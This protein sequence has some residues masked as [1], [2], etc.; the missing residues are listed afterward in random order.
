MSSAP[1][2]VV[3]G[4]TKRFR[5]PHEQ[6]HTLK[7]RALHPFRRTGYDQFVAVDDVAFHVEQGEFFGIAGRNGSGKSTLLK[8]IAGIYRTNAGEIWVNGRMSTFIEL[9][10][11]F[12]PDLAARDN[13]ILNGIML[14]LTPGEARERY[15]RVLEFSELQEFET[16]KLKNYS[17]GMHVRL[18]FAVMIQVDA[19]VLLIDEVLAVGD[20]AFQQKCFD[21]FNKLRDAG[22]TI[23]LVTHDMGAIKRFCHRAM[24]MERGRVVVMGDP[25][26]VGDQYFELNFRRPDP[27]EPAAAPVLHDPLDR[28]GDGR[29][30]WA[31]IWLQTPDGEPLT[32][33]PQGHE[34]VIRGTVEFTE[35]LTDPAIGLTIENADRVPVFSTS[36]MWTEERTG[37][38]RAGD[39]ARVSLRF[40]NVLSPGRYFVTPSITARG[41]GVQVIDR[42]PRMMSFVVTGSVQTGAIVAFEHDLDLARAEALA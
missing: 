7:E 41:S 23:V 13:V 15:E 8:C 24:L 12:N 25:E 11:G 38:W 28:I 39:Y 6:M 10:V 5:R 17:S 19:D 3:E 35:D 20:A 4:V 42:Y 37:T 16:V 14:G 36:T 27:N 40:P 29:A 1:A 21:E 18:A 34:A 30:R 31:Q 26:Y 22:R 32:A 2:I 9:G 33:A